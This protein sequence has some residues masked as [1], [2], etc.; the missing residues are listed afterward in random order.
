M[1]IVYIGTPEFS[2]IPLQ[3]LVDAGHNVKLVVT[4][5]A[6]PK[7]RGKKLQNSPVYDKA[8]SLG[9]NVITPPR[10]KKNEE[11][12]KAI[13]DA[14][15]DFVVVFSYGKMLPIEVLEAP[16]YVCVN[17]HASLLPRYRGAAPIQRAIMEGEEEIG[18]TLMKMEEGLDSGDMYIADKT[19]TE[20][21]SAKMLCDELA[22][23]GAKL[24]V[25]S[26]PKIA[27][28]ELPR[29]PQDDSL[30]NY[31]EMIFKEDGEIKWTNSS[32]SIDCLVRAFNDEPVAWTKLGDVVLKIYE[33]YALPEKKGECGTIWD[34]NK[35]GIFVNT[36]D[37]S[38]V[39]TKLQAP[40]K[41]VLDAR[42]YLAGNH[43][44]IGTK[45]G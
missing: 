18:I 10:L 13:Q 1:D 2:C 29:I 14:K 34:A 45:L 42:D 21:K 23:M 22:T 35:K 19:T 41:K 17:I 24:L 11:A 7:D 8:T 40:G 5:P 30:S 12:I 20:G 31:A 25:D 15:P 33:G 28:G 38:Y 39:I 43:I 3:A 27:S 44:E 32:R 6:K 9:L 36:Q 16:K 4:T 26:L 37:G